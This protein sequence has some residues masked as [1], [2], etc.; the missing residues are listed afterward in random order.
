MKSCIINI[1]SHD[2][3]FP[4][5]AFLA[6]IATK[7]AYMKNRRRIFYPILI[8]V[9]LMG[10]A[11]V[12]LRYI[13]PAAGDAPEIKVEL[14]PVRIE[15]GKYLANHVCVCIDCH[16][17]R[18][19]TLFSG[20]PFEGTEGRGGIKFDHKLGFPG[21]YYA[22]NITPAALK[23][24]T[25]GEIYRAITA[26]VDKKGK[27]ISPIM[28]YSHYAQM[29][30]EDVLAIIAYLRTLKPLSSTVPVSVPDFPVNLILNLLPQKAN[31]VKA[32]DPKDR[33]A[34][35]KYLATIG[36]CA[37]C[38]SQYDRYKMVAG[39]EYGGGRE[40]PFPGL[41]IIRATNIS[42]DKETGIGTWDKEQFVS[43]FKIRS[44][45]SVLNNMLSVG[46]FNS[47]MPWYM[48]GKMTKEDLESIFLY[49][50]SI[51]PIRNEVVK[52]TP[53]P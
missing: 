36:A 23:D 31:P 43:L 37:D 40:F 32:P 42:P 45:S 18:D 4:V 48:Y 6:I 1:E 8:L 25:D 34:Y 35:G 41:G 10:S 7:T 9:L 14:T 11:Y 24:W 20:P 53:Q 52:F 28:P 47:I 46:Q 2:K 50:Q 13:L 49:L 17:K 26:G 19:W 30:P 33:L 51:K 15:R 12:Y 38:H 29:D 27:A 21:T 44:D 5:F 3:I 22:K 16:S 39:T